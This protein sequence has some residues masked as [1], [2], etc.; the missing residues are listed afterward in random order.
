MELL[1]LI[2]IWIVA[3]YIIRLNLELHAYR[4]YLNQHTDIYVPSYD[5]LIST[6]SFISRTISSLMSQ[7]RNGIGRT[8]GVMIPE[9]KKKMIPGSVYAKETVNG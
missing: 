9:Y 8:K 2:M 4:K 7:F 5:E 1:W 6:N 3:L